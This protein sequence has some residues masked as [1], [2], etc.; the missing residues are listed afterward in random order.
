MGE[1]NEKRKEKDERRKRTRKIISVQCGTVA[2]NVRTVQY[3]TAHEQYSKVYVPVQSYASPCTSPSPVSSSSS[4]SI[5][6][7]IFILLSPSTSPSRSS[8]SF[9]LS[10]SAVYVIFLRAL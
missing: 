4:P 10:C 2:S 8:L 5:S 1:G 6:K 7:S 3:S 9:S